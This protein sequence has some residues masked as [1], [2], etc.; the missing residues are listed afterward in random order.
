[1]LFL[2]APILSGLF[3]HAVMNNLR[4]IFSL[5]LSGRISR[6]SYWIDLIVSLALCSLLQALYQQASLSMVMSEN[7]DS[8][9]IGIIAFVEILLFVIVCCQIVRRLHDI[10]RNG[11]WLLVF[12]IPLIGFFAVIV[13]GFLKGAMGS[14]EYGPNPLHPASHVDGV[15]NRIQSLKDLEQLRKDGVLTQTEFEIE[16]DKL[17]K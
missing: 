6:S 15:E 13:L 2:K 5:T 4:N 10:G 8:I 14:N 16:K 17:L 12:F 3:L 11:L 1:M 9:F 7:T